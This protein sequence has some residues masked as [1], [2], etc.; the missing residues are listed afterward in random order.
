V[1]IAVLGGGHVGSALAE[2]WR[3]QG[4][5]V[6]VSTRETVAETASASEVVVLAVPATAVADTLGAA[7]S[8]DGKILVDATNNVSGGPA[9]LVIA[10]LVPGARYVKAFNAVFATFM[11]DT[12]ASPPASLVYCG[13]DAEA[14]E[15]VGGLIRDVG[16]EPVDA[17]GAEV[18]PLVEAFAQLIIGI[19]YAQGRGPFVYRFQIS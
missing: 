1:R 17:G 9:G 11:H 19:A 13:D 2:S 10:E 7:G 18:T 5:D 16:F 14:K 3:E 8:L 6:S 15:V 12:P 4:H